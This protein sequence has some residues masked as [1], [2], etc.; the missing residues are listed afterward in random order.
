MLNSIFYDLRIR[1]GR[2]WRSDGSP[3]RSST[4]WKAS[5]YPNE[6]EADIQKCDAE[7]VPLEPM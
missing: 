2:N 7:D 4:T 6:M 3:T 1:H 5:A